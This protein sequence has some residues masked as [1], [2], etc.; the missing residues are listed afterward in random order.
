ML[1]GR[2]T[3]AVMPTGSGKSAIY[4]IA[5]A[6]I[7]GATLVVSPLIALQKDQLDALADGSTSAKR[8]R[9]T[10]RCPIRSARRRWHEM[11]DDRLEFVFMAPEQFNNEETHAN[12]WRRTR[13]RCSSSTRRTA[14]AS[15][16]TT[17]GPTI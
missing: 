12:G 13:R 6:L 7:P 16:A 4:Q 10:R 15:G 1:A 11:E 9:L 17:F 2:D 5:G 8:P 14:S 3:L